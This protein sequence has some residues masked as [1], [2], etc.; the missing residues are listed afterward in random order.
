MRMLCNE[1]FQLSELEK[2]R[3]AIR[4]GQIKGLEG[5]PKPEGLDEHFAALD[6]LLAYQRT[7]TDY[8]SLSAENAEEIKEELAKVYGLC[9]FG[10][11]L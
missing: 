2:T 1:L 7:I 8:D 10:V 4:N 3:E 5:F 11:L 9:S 6:K